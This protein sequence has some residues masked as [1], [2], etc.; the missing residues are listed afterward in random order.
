MTPKRKPATRL[1]SAAF[2]ELRRVPGNQRMALIT[3]IDNLEKNLR[4]HISKELEMDDTTRE[5]RRLR[6]GKWRII[7]LIY[8]E[9]PIVIG[10]RQRPPYDYQDLDRLL[11]TLKE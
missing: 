11:S 4:P 8:D 10:I 9:I 2:A 6:L 1:T 5:V 3:A 7:Y